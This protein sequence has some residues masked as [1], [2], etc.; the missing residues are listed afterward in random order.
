MKT[1]RL[2]TKYK[3][4]ANSMLFSMLGELPQ[5]EL[6]KQR[7][8]RFG[9][10]VHT[11]NHVFVID[12]VFKAHLQGYAHDYTA[13]NT[14][15]HPSVQDLRRATAEM[16]AWYVEYAQSLSESKLDEVVEFDFIGGGTGAMTRR[17]M[18]LHTVNHATYHRGFVGDMLY[19]AGVDPRA[20][21]L[22]VYLRDAR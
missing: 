8:T 1:V 20:T 16:D 4:W 17:E 9:N 15:T 7:P 19:Q 14:P 13:R 5:D 10:M 11:I 21:D 22:S 2:M 3:A 6:V 12:S 18:I